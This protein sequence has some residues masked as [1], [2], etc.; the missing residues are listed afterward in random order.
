M[1]KMLNISSVFKV[2]GYVDEYYETLFLAG[3]AMVSGRK[4]VQSVEFFR[5]IQKNIFNTLHGIPDEV[6]VMFSKSNDNSPQNEVRKVPENIP[7]RKQESIASVSSELA[8]QKIDKATFKKLIHKAAKLEILIADCCSQHSQLQEKLDALKK[9]T[10]LYRIKTLE[11]F[12]AQVPLNSYISLNKSHSDSKMLISQ[13]IQEEDIYTELLKLHPDLLDWILLNLNEKVEPIRVAFLKTLEFL[14]DTLGCSLGP[15][16]SKILKSVIK[17]VN[18]TEK[19]G[20]DS[21]C[22]SRKVFNQTLK[23]IYNHFLESFLSVLSSMSNEILLDLFNEVLYPTIMQLKF[24]S[25]TTGDQ[26][27]TTGIFATDI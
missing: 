8:S 26:I 6:E 21:T 16:I 1:I 11:E 7:I 4:Y 2:N 27:H 14:L 22:Q 20:K 19:Q 12:K 23:N 9:S 15:Y 24:D 5:H 18:T 13:F 10:A 25:G 3:L 17:H